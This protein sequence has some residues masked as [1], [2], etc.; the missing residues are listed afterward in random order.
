[1]IKKILERF[2]EWKIERQSAKFAI[3]LKKKKYKSGKP[4]NVGVWIF[5]GILLS[6]TQLEGQIVKLLPE[7]VPY[8]LVPSGDNF[9]HM[10]IEIVEPQSFRHML[11]I[12]KEE[13]LDIL[14]E[15]AAHEM[16]QPHEQGTIFS[17][18]N[19]DYL[20]F[21]LPFDVAYSEWYGRDTKYG[22]YR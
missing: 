9:C 11:E 15:R 19:K 1:M 3:E 21:R 18:D 10:E 6:L 22:E 16:M 2:I 12:Q 20:M 14:K 5:I 7:I 8:R 13:T 4:W 17:I